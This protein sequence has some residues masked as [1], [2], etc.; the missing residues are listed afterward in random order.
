MAH[1][2]H[3][4]TRGPLYPGPEFTL[5]ER[6]A[7]GTETETETEQN[8]YIYIAKYMYMHISVY[9]MC[10]YIYIYIYIPRGPSVLV[11][12]TGSYL[13]SIFYRKL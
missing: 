7:T 1:P 8:V 11:L 10:A 3:C 9:Y 4:R 5:A 12:R 6:I 2:G 13:F